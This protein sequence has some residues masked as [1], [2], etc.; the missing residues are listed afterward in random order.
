MQNGSNPAVQC[1]QLQAY[2]A[3]AKKAQE[4]FEA[5]TRALEIKYDEQQRGIEGK[6]DAAIAR[7]IASFEIAQRKIDG[8]YNDATQPHTDVLHRA[9]D[10]ASVA[11]DQ[12]IGTAMSV[13]RTTCSMPEN[14]SLDAIPFGPER[15][16]FE[17]E[18]EAIRAVSEAARRQA[19]ETFQIAFKPIEALWTL[20]SRQNRAAVK[21]AE[22]R[23]H[24]AFRRK[25]R[26]MWKSREK[27]AAALVEDF[28]ASREQRM[29]IWQQYLASN[30]QAFEQL[31]RN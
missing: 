16:R 9:F 5:S 24:E 29:A 12:A 13:V 22:Q 7:A 27:D 8:L 14:S 3:D 21:E 23:V 1:E 28:R 20:A 26:K 31:S 11:S 25:L 30:E 19:E 4:T 15:D 10:L 18:R 17:K 2:I 6:R